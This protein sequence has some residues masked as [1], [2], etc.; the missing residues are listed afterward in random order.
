[1][2]PDPEYKVHGDPDCRID[3][4]TSADLEAAW[5]SLID[6]GKRNLVPIWPGLALFPR[7]GCGCW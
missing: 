7:A 1:M 3:L 6:K 2:S 4:S 5:Q